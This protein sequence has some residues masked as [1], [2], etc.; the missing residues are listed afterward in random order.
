MSIASLISGGTDLTQAVKMLEAQ[1]D[2][3][4][5]AELTVFR[6]PDKQHLI[7]CANDTSADFWGVFHPS[8]I[9]TGTREI[10]DLLP[11]TIRT[12]HRGYVDGLFDAPRPMLMSEREELKA[13]RLDNNELFD[14]NVQLRPIYLGPSLVFLPSEKEIREGLFIQV[15][16]MRVSDWNRSGG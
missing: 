14:V 9:A 6:N 12:V 10:H 4:P 8:Q 16:V 13:Q 1:R 15:Y 7:V 5:L 3:S 2:K 11:E